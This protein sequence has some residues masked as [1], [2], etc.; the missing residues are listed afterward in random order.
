MDTLSIPAPRFTEFFDG[1]SRR[2]SGD[3]VTLE[4][5]GAEFGAQVEGHRLRLRGISANSQGGGLAIMLET[6]DGAH[7]TH[8]IARPQQVWL[9]RGD[10]TAWSIGVTSAD[11]IRTL[12]AAEEGSSGALENRYEGWNASE[13]FR[14][15][16]RTRRGIG[17][18]TR[19]EMRSWFGDDAAR[20]RRQLDARE[21]D[22]E[23]DRRQWQ[24]SQES[25]W[26][27]VPD[28]TGP[29]MV[30]APVLAWPDIGGARPGPHVGK[31][32]RGARRSD[33]R[34]KEDVS[35]RLAISPVLDASEI[36]VDVRDGHVTLTGS[37]TDRSDKRLAEDLAY[38]IRG[39]QDVLNRLR[40]RARP[41]AMES[42]SESGSARTDRR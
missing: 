13:R 37:V 14:P 30:A 10:D 19:D 11:G 9:Q 27:P 32:P 39:V 40:A 38:S 25:E 28:W 20:R 23:A 17:E 6:P 41:T 4:A 35:D 8:T 34:I 33:D 16:G 42:S 24:Y 18:R 2:H 21:A 29:W 12:L 36:T 3:L 26:L 5:H 22:R 15:D 7:L 1:F 31:G